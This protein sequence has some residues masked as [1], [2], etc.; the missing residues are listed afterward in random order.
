MKPKMARKP[1]P[2]D[3]VSSPP[4]SPTSGRMVHKK[5][6]IES[7]SS[8]PVRKQS[9]ASMGEKACKQSPK[10]PK[11]KEP[12][13][14]ECKVPKEDKPMSPLPPIHVDDQQPCSSTAPITTVQAPPEFL[15]F[16]YNLQC[17]TLRGVLKA[18]ETLSSIKT[19]VLRA[20][21]HELEAM[22]AHTMDFMRRAAGDLQFLETGDYPMV[23]LK[24][25]AMPCYQMRQ[26]PNSPM[27]PTTQV[28][29]EISLRSLLIPAAAPDEDVDVWPPPHL[30]TRYQSYLAMEKEE[31][32][33]DRKALD[34]FAKFMDDEMNEVDLDFVTVRVPEYRNRLRYA[35][36][37]D[38]FSE[39]ERRLHDHALQL[40][41][42]NTGRSGGKVVYNNCARSSTWWSNPIAG[43]GAAEAFSRNF[44]EK[45]ESFIA[46]RRVKM[47]RVNLLPSLSFQSLDE[48]RAAAAR[49]SALRQENE[50]LKEKLKKAE[51]K[52]ETLM[53]KEKKVKEKKK[54]E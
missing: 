26:A 19:E 16:D 40:Q 41:Q 38:V 33:I 13:V 37:L 27:S 50:E 51:E 12:A 7:E 14:R 46:E 1:R 48:K 25:R 5:R 52:E 3:E 45:R 29:H 49:E 24:N 9:T 36:M 42:M 10:G 44:R 4:L 28:H 54:E 34:E 47:M 8:S 15:A 22:L 21:Q 20:L 31:N 2:T 17:P 11:H 43:L 39:F 30:A 18:E 6:R 53:D 23:N 32:V 35:S